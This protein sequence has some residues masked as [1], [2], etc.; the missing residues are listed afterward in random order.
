MPFLPVPLWPYKT[1][2]GAVAL[3]LSHLVLAS[4]AYAD[5][6]CASFVSSDFT[7]NNNGV[8]RDCQVGNNASFTT[9]AGSGVEQ[10]DQ[11]AAVQFMTDLGAGKALLN[12]GIIDATQMVEDTNYGIWVTRDLAGTLT[13]AGAVR[14]GSVN[15]GGMWAKA[16][17]IYIGGDLSGTLTN[18]RNISV[19]AANSAGQGLA[20]AD[21][22]YSATISGQLV[23]NGQIA[24]TASNSGS[25]GDIRLHGI[26]ADTVSGGGSLINASGGV[27]NV[28]AAGETG[29]FASVNGITAGTVASG[30]R[31]GNAGTI[32]ATVSGSGSGNSGAVGISVDSLVSGGQLDNSGTITALSTKTASFNSIVAGIAVGTLDGSVSNSGT[33]S[34]RSDTIGQGF[35]LL[36]EGGR[37]TANNLTGGLLQGSLQLGNREE[38]DGRPSL[39]NAG[40]IDL[41]LKDTGYVAGNFTQTGTGVLRIAAQSSLTGGYSQLAVDGIVSLAGSADV[42]VKTANTLAV[43]QKLVGVVTAGAGLSGN[44]SKVTDNSA[45]F[46]FRSLAINSG[47]GGRIDLEVVQSQGSSASQAVISNGNSPALGAARVF[48]RLIAAGNAGGD[49]GTVITALGQLG[50]EREV[51]NAVSQTLPLLTAGASQATSG[52]LHGTNRV[53]QA[54]QEGQH[55]RSSGDEFFADRRVW[56]KPFGSWADQADSNGASGYTARTYGMVVGADTELNESSR[57]GVAVAY[58]SSKVDGKDSAAQQ[59]ADVDTYQLVAYGSHSLSEATDLNFQADVGVHRTS[60]ERQIA[61]GGLSRTAKS[62]YNSWSAHFG[63]GLAHTLMLGERTSFTPSLRADYAVI[64][65]HGYRETGAGALNLNVDSNRA[66]ELIVGVDG[67]LSQTLNE[68]TTLVANLGAGYDLLGKQ[69]SIVSAF[70]GTPSAAFT[71]RGIEPSKWLG[72]GGLG[73]V[74]KVSDTLELSAR[75]DIEFR[76]GFTN[77]TASVKAR[78]IF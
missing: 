28:S 14:A 57:L 31:L 7:L 20:I 2:S 11:Q 40:T 68:R 53:V 69:S 43:G 59:R 34:G 73:L 60:G 39:H 77:Q 21:G 18:N 67:K 61:F 3:A 41:G 1:L 23:N 32:S 76:E 27:I 66:E 10:Q 74:N 5:Q 70:A 48:D 37:G 38:P 64:R 45:L 71:T 19:S 44:F 16:Y 26:E 75:Y 51:S 78:W 4:N 12:N 25:N 29:G 49:M 52:A 33:V 6:P 13:N 62:D 56:A 58:A 35:S 46:D 63:A 22:I 24:G 54:R 8:A 50:S 65:D 30:A 36:V 17:G 42:D 9:G 47:E 15:S 55:G 72:R